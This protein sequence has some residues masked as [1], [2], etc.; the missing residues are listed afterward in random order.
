MDSAVL[1]KRLE[2]ETKAR[3]EAE[4]LLEEK[5]RALFDSNENLRQTTRALEHQSK[6]LNAILDNTLAGIALVDEQGRIRRVNQAFL[7][8]FAHTEAEIIGV[9]ASTMLLTEGAITSKPNFDVSGPPAVQTYAAE[10]RRRGGE[11]FPMSLTTVPLVIDSRPHTVWICRDQTAELEAENDRARLEHE[12]AQA[13]KLESLGVMASGIAHEIN[14][15]VQ[16]VTDNVKFL[17]AAAS[18]LKRAFEAYQAVCQSIDDY[19]KATTLASTAQSIVDEADIG[20]VLDE[21]PDAL[22]HAIDGLTQ[23]TKI[24]GAVKTFAHPGS[25]EKSETDVNDLLQDTITVSRNEWKYVA[26][27]ETD[28]E[29]SLPLIGCFPQELSQVFLNLIVNAA[30]AIDESGRDDGRILIATRSTENGVQIEIKDNGCG[31]KSNIKSKIFDPFFTTKDVGKGTGQ[32]LSLCYNVITHHHGGKI[33]VDSQEGRGAR[34]IVSLPNI[35]S[36]AQASS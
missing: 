9:I 30:Q 19:S 8:L 36:T 2:R 21:L 10:G 15:P 16:Y 24:V 22:N 32:G 29:D 31:V 27:L 6:E 3:C 11:P 26:A 18:D 5:S 12:L 28:F 23:I 14:T 7:T 20:F 33:T 17:S 35:S 1:H 34:F 4:R 13:Q 25:S